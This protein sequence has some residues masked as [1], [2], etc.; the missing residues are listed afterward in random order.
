ML[1]RSFDESVLAP[2]TLDIT[3]LIT[4]LFLAVSEIK[5]FSVDPLALAKRFID[6]YSTALSEGKA[7]WIERDT[8]KGLVEELLDKAEESNRID[9]LD[10]KAPIKNNVR[11]IKI[12]KD[13]TLKV[14]SE[15]S[16]SVKA[17]MKQFAQSQENPEFFDMIDVAWRIAGT[18]SLGLERYIVLVKGKGNGSPDD[19][20]LLDI[21]LAIE[22]SLPQF[23]KDFPQWQW[24]NESQRIISNQKKI[25]AINPA[26]LNSLTI[27]GKFFV[28]REYQ[29][30]EEKIEISSSELNLDQKSLEELIETL[31]KVVAW[32]QLRSSGRKGSA[33]A[34]ALI[35]FAQNNRWHQAVLEYAQNYSQIVKANYEEF[36][37]NLE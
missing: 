10:K 24:N 4:S 16:A 8:A 21:K 17:A 28:M 34:D 6:S 18:G 14:S 5:A 9:F 19:N 11:K 27:D 22:P 29:P 37:Q 26:L 20:Y 7:R 1:F 15:T 13:K 2:C 25:Q 3:R 23:L 30:S 35:E 32:S 36:K 12:K 33:N 31:G